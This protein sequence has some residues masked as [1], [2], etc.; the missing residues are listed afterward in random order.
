MPGQETEC[1]FEKESAFSR[2]RVPFREMEYTFERWRIVDSEGVEL[3]VVDGW[4]G[5][6]AFWGKDI[7]VVE[8]WLRGGVE[9]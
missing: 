9:C 8:R 1:T 2:N 7:E 6:C 3:W 5:G 4:G